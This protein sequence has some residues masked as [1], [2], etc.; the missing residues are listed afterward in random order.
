M[1]RRA[2]VRVAAQGT[3]RPWETSATSSPPQPLHGEA[4]GRQGTARRCRA[5]RCFSSSCSPPRC[6][7]AKVSSISLATQPRIFLGGMGCPQQSASPARVCTAR[8]CCGPPP[9][10]RRGWGGCGAG[11]G[12]GTCRRQQLPEHG[13]GGWCWGFPSRIPAG[14]LCPDNS[15]LQRSGEVGFVKR[16]FIS[17]NLLWFKS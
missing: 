13:F 9:G 15:A 2:S 10:A 5:P 17:Y 12:A 6:L 1:P 7:L 8:G 4:R 3:P 16:D 11:S 14:L